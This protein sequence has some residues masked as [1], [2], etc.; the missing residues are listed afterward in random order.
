MCESKRC[1]SS[2]TSSARS[3]LPKLTL[4]Q[5]RTCPFC[6]KTR[7]YLDYTKIPYDIVEVNPVFKKEMKFSEY[8]HVPFVVA[9][10]GTQVSMEGGG[11]GGEIKCV[12][13]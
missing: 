12:K 2:D 1:V 8:R 10:D 4:Y 7:A 13:I 5:Y 6:C 9:N 3:S 11:G